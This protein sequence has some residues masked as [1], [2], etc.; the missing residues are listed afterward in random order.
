MFETRDIFEPFGCAAVEGQRADNHGS[1]IQEGA[2]G[3][4]IAVWYG[5]TAEKHEDVQI[6]M[7]KKLPGKEEWLKPWVCEKEG[8]TSKIPDEMEEFAGHSSEGNPVIYYEKEQDR[9][10]L[11][12][13][14][15]YG[16][17][18]SRGWSTGFIKYKHS[19]DG[20]KSWTLRE[21]GQPRL[22]HDFWGEMIKNHPIKLSNGEVILP[23]MTEWTSY[24]PIF[25]KASAEEFKKGCLE[26]NWRKIQTDGT[27]CFQPTIAEIKQGKILCFLRSSKKG[28]FKGVMT[29]MKSN[30]YGESWTLP[31]E[32]DHGFP[33]PDANNDMVKLSNGHLVLVYNDSSRI[34]NPLT[35]ALSEDGGKSFPFKKNIVF[36]SNVNDRFAYPSVI[37]A[38]DGLI[39]VTYSNGPSGNIKWAC[40][41]EDWIKE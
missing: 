11:W 23:A 29:Q 13:I 7:S 38:S 16:F 21:N 6:W 12:W 25:Y 15:I 4:I 33:N 24:S 19:D 26:S 17:G 36:T 34:R 5:G 9:L 32:N 3:E 30:D 27:G 40:F 18:S 14:T 20:G 39:H 2:D 28:K 22:L 8:K 41:D 1:N 35:A 37:Q 31:H 10:H